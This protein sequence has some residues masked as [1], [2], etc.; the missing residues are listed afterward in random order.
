MRR[1]L[2]FLMLFTPFFA[3]ANLGVLF[4]GTLKSETKVI[5]AAARKSARVLRYSDIYFR[6]SLM[7]SAKELITSRSLFKGVSRNV[8]RFDLDRAKDILDFGADCAS[9]IMEQEAQIDRASLSNKYLNEIRANPTYKL[10]Y[11]SVCQKFKVDT[12]NSF[13]QLYLLSGGSWNG[14]QFSMKELYNLYLIYSE[15]FAKEEL[16]KLRNYYKCNAEKNQEI[17]SFA[18]RMRIKLPKSTCPEEEGDWVD[19]LLGLLGLGLLI[20]LVIG[21]LKWFKRLISKLF[22]LDADAE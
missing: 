12:L 11:Q 8:K 15:S 20:Y 17:E 2:V 7:N 9:N 19:G 18:N 10:L 16:L 4:K 5:S 6:F 13:A 21:L 1:L 3:D 14:E 22:K